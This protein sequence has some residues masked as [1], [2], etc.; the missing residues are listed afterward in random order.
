MDSSLE[1]F[2]IFLE[3][4]I[5]NP[6]LVDVRKIRD[7]ATRASTVD[8]ALSFSNAVI[9]KSTKKREHRQSNIV[10]HNQ[11]QYDRLNVN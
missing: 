5:A 4:L 8:D 1:R 11:K 7:Y 3:W 6:S 2:Q 10:R 9:S